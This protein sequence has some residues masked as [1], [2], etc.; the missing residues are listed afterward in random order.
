VAELV[1]LMSEFGTRGTSDRVKVALP[2]SVDELFDVLVGVELIV[3]SRL[4]GILLAHLVPTPVLAVSY[5]RKVDAH[6]TDMG[7]QQYRVD[8]S[9]ASAK[10]LEAAFDVLQAHREEITRE[11]AARQESRRM[12]LD[13]QFDAILQG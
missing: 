1:A 13:R 2:S 3:A 7:Q 6:M 11:L 12:Q 4:H 8:I 10:E 9:N 5:D